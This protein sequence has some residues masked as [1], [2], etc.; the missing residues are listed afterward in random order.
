VKI[1][2]FEEIGP[3]LRFLPLAARR[4]LDRAGIKISLSAWLAM[5]LA[6]RRA[7]IRAGCT[8]K[9]DPGRVEK[10]IA[11]AGVP[12]ASIE[13]S[14][15]PRAVPAELREIVSAERWKELAPV[16]R[17]ALVKAAQK[18]AEHLRVAT[19]EIVAPPAWSNHLAS[20]GTVRMVGVGHKETSARRA[21]ARARVTMQPS[22]FEL[23]SQGKTPK[24]DALA[25]ARIAGIQAAKRTSELI[26][27]CHNIALTKVD[28]TIGLTDGGATIDAAAEAHDRTGVEMEAMVAAS[29]AALT[30]Y[31]MLKGIDRDVAFTVHLREKT[32]GQ[33]GPWT[34]DERK[35]RR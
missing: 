23:L 31:D 11:R 7:L 13:K 27:L 10:V 15:E 28:I 8:A 12:R 1:F 6:A 5:D 34:R 30:L 26:P 16:E 19:A 17:Y 33:S 22:T 25:T 24:G 32:G 4:A 18:G 3:D 2:A 35:A 21:V 20:D 29:T 14:P 9:V